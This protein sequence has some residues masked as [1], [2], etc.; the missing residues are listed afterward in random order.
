MI[1]RAQ[2]SKNDPNSALLGITADDDDGM[3][4]LAMTNGIEDRDN[5]GEEDEDD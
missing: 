2:K 1:L 4:G 3:E 5:A